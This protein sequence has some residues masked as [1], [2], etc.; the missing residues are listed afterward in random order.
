MNFSQRRKAG[1]ECAK[2]PLGK[3]LG[4]LCRHFGFAKS[5][6]LLPAAMLL[7][8]PLAGVFVAGLPVSRFLAFPPDP[9]RVPHAPFSWFVFVLYSV[10]ILALVVPLLWTGMRRSVV[11]AVPVRSFPW[12]GFASFLAMLGFW[13]LAWHRY[14][15]FRVF[16]AY[17]FAPLWLSYILVVSALAVRRSGTCLLTNHPGFFL[18]LFPASG[19]FWWFFEYLNRFVQNWSY[20]GV[21]FS[22]WQ[23]FWHASISFSTVLPAVAATQQWLFAALGLDQRFDGQ[24]CLRVA[25]PRQTAIAALGLSGIGLAGIG[26]F[27][28]VFFSL[29]WVSPLVILIATQTLSGRD[30][31]LTPLARGNW[32]G[33]VSWALAALVCGFFWEMWN[34]HSMARWVYSVAYV[35]RFPIF[36]MPLLGYAG[37]LP[38]GLECAAVIHILKT[39]RK[40]TV[41]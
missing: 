1:A 21:A 36:E 2:R 5:A 25:Y 22:A 4:G 10:L 19:A 17:T 38:F 35:Q 15:W 8:L 32:S 33:P 23:Y 24:V 13:V 37:Y 20:Q 12:W 16:Q 41:S 27:P 18:L 39:C 30:H 3:G 34:F 29:L 11:I 7:G 6:L 14:V 9:G 31:V 40:D 26:V 28:D